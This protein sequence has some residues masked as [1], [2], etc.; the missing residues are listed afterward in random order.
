MLGFQLPE[1]VLV[2][3]HEPFQFVPLGEGQEVGGVGPPQRVVLPGRR[4]PVG[5][6]FPDRFQQAIAWNARPA[7]FQLNQAV[8]DQRAEAIQDGRGM[9]DEA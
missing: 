4:Q 2:E 3:G 5:R 6:V 7:L 9:R 1:P 8:V